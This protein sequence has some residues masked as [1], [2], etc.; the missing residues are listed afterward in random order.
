MINIDKDNSLLT[1]GVWMEYEGSKFLVTHMSNVAFQRAVMRR[2][3]PHKSKIDKGTLDPALMREM[4]TRAMS[5]ALLL[6]WADVV[7]GNGQKVP[8]SAEAGYKALKNNEDLRDYIS[9]FALNLDNFREERK[10]ELGKS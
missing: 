5:E 2:Q 10:E 3:A 8:Y 6:D 7:D 1:A 9:D 4:M